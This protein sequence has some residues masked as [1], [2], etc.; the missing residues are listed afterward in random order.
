MLGRVKVRLGLCQRCPESVAVSTESTRIVRLSGWAL[1]H[2]NPHSRYFQTD[3]EV[4]GSPHLTWTR[5]VQ[6]DRSC[7]LVSGQMCP[8]QYQTR[9]RGPE[10]RWPISSP[11]RWQDQRNFGR[12][13]QIFVHTDEV[14]PLRDSRSVNAAPCA[15]G[16]PR[17][18]CNGPSA[19][20]AASDAKRTFVRLAMA[21]KCQ[22]RT[23]VTWPRQAR[24]K[25]SAQRRG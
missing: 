13:A 22:F 14:S 5:S 6:S 15:K 25:V 21:E 1:Q 11:P 2:D 10:A 19:Q 4:L 9:S 17:E 16:A 12:S 20:K 8:R 7:Q 24:S 18:R 23:H 3:A